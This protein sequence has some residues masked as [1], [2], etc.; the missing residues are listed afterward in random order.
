MFF[1]PFMLFLSVVAVNL[2]ICRELCVFAGLFIILGTLVKGS[3]IVVKRGPWR[4]NK[5]STSTNPCSSPYA[6]LATSLREAL[7]REVQRGEN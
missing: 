6:C 2:E 4:V 3:S 1:S 7:E 5:V